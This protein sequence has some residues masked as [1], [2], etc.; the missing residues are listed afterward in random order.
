MMIV[1][2]RILILLVS[3][4]FFTLVCLWPSPHWIF[5]E[6]FCP[7]TFHTEPNSFLSLMWLEVQYL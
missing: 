7:L 6:C 5:F 4:F 3:D 2:E 1:I